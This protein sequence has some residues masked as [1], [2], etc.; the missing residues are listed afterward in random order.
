MMSISQYSG[1]STVK[2]IC[3][4]MQLAFILV[5]KQV[6]ITNSSHWNQPL[7]LNS[8]PSIESHSVCSTRPVV[9]W[10]VVDASSLITRVTNVHR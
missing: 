8:V 1:A 3:V 7:Q 9:T 10:F 2:K 5:A 4:R 6:V